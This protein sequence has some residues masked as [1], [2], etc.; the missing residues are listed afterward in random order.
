M[1]YNF[2]DGDGEGQTIGIL[3]FGGGYFENDLKEFCD[4]AGIS[5]IPTVKTISVDGTPTDSNDEATGEVM[6]DIEV[7]AGICPKAKIVVYFANF[8]DQGFVDALN[9]SI[10]DQENDP[11][12]IS[13]SWGWAEGQIL[14]GGTGMD[15]SGNEQCE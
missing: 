1:H 12:V 3:E 13:I 8:G 10:S 15:S 9:S 2:P 14:A 4:L 7:A 6:L 11:G 5:T